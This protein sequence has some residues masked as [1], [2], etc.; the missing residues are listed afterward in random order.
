MTSR[1]SGWLPKGSRRR[2]G[3]DRADVGDIFELVSVGLAD[4]LW[5]VEVHGDLGCDDVV[6]VV[7]VG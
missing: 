1:T 5:A 4:V 6:D 2:F 3:A 7:D